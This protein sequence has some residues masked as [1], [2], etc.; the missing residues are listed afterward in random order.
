MTD[1]SQSSLVWASSPPRL[2]HGR[3]LARHRRWK[4]RTPPAHAVPIAPHGQLPVGEVTHDLS[5]LGAPPTV[6]AVTSSLDRRPDALRSA[7]LDPQSAADR[8]GFYSAVRSAA[9]S[10]R[11]AFSLRSLNNTRCAHARRASMNALRQ[12]T[13]RGL[14]RFIRSEFCHFHRLCS[15]GALAI[16]TAAELI[17]SGQTDVM[18]AGGTDSLSHTTWAGFHS[19]LS[20]IHKAAAPLM[21]RGGMSFGEGAA[22]LIIEAEA[23]ARKRGAKVLRPPHRLGRQLR[24]PSRHRAHPDG[25]P[26]RSPQCKPPCAAPAFHQPTST[27]STP[28]ALAR[29]I[30]TSP[31]PKH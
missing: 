15:S 31:K 23:H 20:W 10:T 25:A 28:T 6:R 16:A 2:R 1:A 17:Q 19:L 4:K 24:C 12:W 14:L 11:N 7:Q 13:G 27:T 5:A 30:T 9:R 18:L 3:N 22:V 8:T 29:A 26:V 21:P